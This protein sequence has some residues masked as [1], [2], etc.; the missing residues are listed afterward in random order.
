MRAEA[1]QRVLERS[2]SGR[3]WSDPGGRKEGRKMRKRKGS[4]LRGKNRKRKGGR[5]GK[6]REEQEERKGGTR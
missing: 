2:E 3:P 6:E 1:E 4:V 5:R